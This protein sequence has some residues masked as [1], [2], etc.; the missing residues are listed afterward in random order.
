MRSARN[1][2]P[3]I[4]TT[5]PRRRGGRRESSRCTRTSSGTTARGRE[6]A[7]RRALGSGRRRIAQLLLTES[8]LLAIAG[9]ALGLLLAVWGVDLLLALTPAELPRLAE[10]RI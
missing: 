10:V 7:V 6:L 4:A 8:V 2:A 9:G 3:P 5:I 1:C